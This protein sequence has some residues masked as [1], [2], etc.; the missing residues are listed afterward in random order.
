MARDIYIKWPN[1]SVMPREDFLATNS[2]AMLGFVSDVSA[3]VTL[4]HV[5]NINNIRFYVL[6]FSFF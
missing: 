2:T 4:R 1:A 5:F 3:A 6:V